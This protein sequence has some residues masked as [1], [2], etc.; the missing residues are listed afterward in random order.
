MRYRLRTPRFTG[1][2]E[3]P[4]DRHLQ[5][6][7]HPTSRDAVGG[8]W[9]TCAPLC[10]NRRRAHAASIAR[11]V[12]ESL[13]RP[14]A[15]SGGGM[16]PP[17]AGPPPS[18]AAPAGLSSSCAPVRSHSLMRDSCSCHLAISARACSSD[19]CWV[20]VSVLTIRTASL[21]LAAAPASP[22]LPSPPPPPLRWAATTSRNAATCASSAD[23][24]SR[25]AAFSLPSDA[26]DRRSCVVSNS[27]DDA[28][29][30]RLEFSCSSRKRR[31]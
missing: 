30:S 1:T 10:T 23:C 8:R 12:Q 19:S 25:S 27:A 22:P 13:H 26:T 6:T 17:A 24:C 20:C 31:F 28:V 11:G 4:T 15:E 29:L 18:A 21:L 5:T 9:G 3:G 16:P 2:P 7:T 14:I